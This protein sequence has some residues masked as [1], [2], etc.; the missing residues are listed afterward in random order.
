MF[1]SFFKAG[2]HRRFDY[3]PRYYNS[4]V[5]RIQKRD[6]KINRVNQFQKPII[7]ERPKLLSFKSS[8]R[9]YL[10]WILITIVLYFLVTYSF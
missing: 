6:T 4:D 8:A 1:N 5:E 10:R 3:T 2:K 7:F 9:V